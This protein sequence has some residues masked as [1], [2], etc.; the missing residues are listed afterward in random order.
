MELRAVPAQK[1]LAPLAVLVPIGATPLLGFWALSKD[2]TTLG[3]LFALLVLA[4]GLTAVAVAGRADYGVRVSIGTAVITWVVAVLAL[5]VWYAL[6]ISSSIC[7]KDLA[8]AWAWLPPTGGSLVFLIVG[9]LGLRTRR[10]FTVV[11]VAGL[12]GVLA[13]LMLVAAVPGTQSFCET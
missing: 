10:N 6:E 7:N 1:L 11:P 2:P 3:P 13:F 12:L 4:G 5:P 8:A 9:S